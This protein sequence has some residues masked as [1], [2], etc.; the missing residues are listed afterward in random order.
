[1]ANLEDDPKH[2]EC[3]LLQHT[4]T[5]KYWDGKGFNQKNKNKSILAD[6]RLARTLKWEHEF[7]DMKL[8]LVDWRK[9]ETWSH[10]VSSQK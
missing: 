2:F 4:K 6:C 8:V 10:L 9:D 3:Y 5:K 1:M 7:V